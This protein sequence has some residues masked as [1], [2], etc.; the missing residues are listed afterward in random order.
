LFTHILHIQSHALIQDA[1][2][3]LKKVTPADVSET[4]AACQWRLLI[5]LRSS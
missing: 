1:V 5:L 3:Y 4:E 2:I